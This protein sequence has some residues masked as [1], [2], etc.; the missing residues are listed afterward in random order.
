MPYF[1]FFVG[2]IPAQI[3]STYPEKRHFLY[4]RGLPYQRSYP[5]LSTGPSTSVPPYLIVMLTV[6]ARRLL[7]NEKGR[8]EKP[9]ADLA[10]L[11]QTNLD[12]SRIDPFVVGSSEDFR[13]I[14]QSCLGLV[15]GQLG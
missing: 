7:P 2:S 10:E 5:N 13:E 14:E 11:K 6:I 12:L 8:V 3:G 9:P 4:S 15:F 1:L